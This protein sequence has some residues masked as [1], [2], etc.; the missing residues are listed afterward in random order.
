[1]VSSRPR[2][3]ISRLATVACAVLFYGCAPDAGAAPTDDTAQRTKGKADDPVSAVWGHNLTGVT[4]DADGAWIEVRLRE[5][6]PV[7]DAMHPE[8]D[9]DSK[10]FGQSIHPDGDLTRLRFH[11]TTAELNAIRNGARSHLRTGQWNQ[12]DSKADESGVPA[13]TFQRGAL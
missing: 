3:R 2:V 9:L 12:P 7:T 13:P 10:R 6:L 11:V 5:A 8:L 4:P 1:M